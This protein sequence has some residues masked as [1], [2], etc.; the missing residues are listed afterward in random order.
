MTRCEKRLTILVQTRDRY[1]QP[2][3]IDFTGFAN[4][5][6]RCY[7]RITQ[8]DAHVLT[9]EIIADVYHWVVIL[10][11]AMPRITMVFLMLPFFSRLV[12]PN[13]VRNGIVVSLALFILP[14][15]SAQ[16]SNFQLDPIWILGILLKEAGIGIV[17]GYLSALIFWAV[18][19]AGFFIDLHRGA[20]SSTLFSP[21][22]GS[23]TSPLGNFF[24]HVVATLFFVSGGFLILLNVIFL[25]YEVWPVHAYI[26]NFSFDD[27]IL[28]LQ[29]MDR[30]MVYTLLIAGPI[31][32]A[33]ALAEI[34]MA[35]I[36]RFVPSINIFLLAMP[37]KS[38]LAFLLLGLY[39]RYL[40]NYLDGE[41][42]RIQEVFEMLKIIF[43]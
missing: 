30:L 31:V 13:L 33:M 34:G 6:R 25:S 27:H 38:A 26:P 28:F 1:T 20:M 18:A 8:G 3:W 22:I 14:S 21:L 5:K 36:G 37:I 41:F 29:Q 9:M 7:G 4:F 16:V 32:A 23:P 40:V 2:V 15:V 11:L 35:L 43:K 24:T 39:M 19:S 12:L 17:I 42:I 10:A